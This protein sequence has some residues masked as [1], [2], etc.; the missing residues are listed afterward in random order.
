MAVRPAT[1]LHGERGM[2]VKDRYQVKPIKA[3]ETYDWL[4]NKHYAKR[5]PGSIL[6]SFGLYD[7]KMLLGV[8]TFGM[9]PNYNNNNIGDYPCIELNRLV[10]NDDVV[11]NTMSWFISK[12]M[13]Y[14]KKP[15]AVI[16][17]ADQG[18]N[19]FGVIYQASN[20][21]YTGRST[22]VDLYEMKNGKILSKRA[23]DQQKN[24]ESMIKSIHKKTYKH[25][26][27][28]FLGSKKDR[29]RM[30]KLLPYQVQPYPK[31]DNQRYDASYRPN[32]QQTLF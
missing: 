12:S 31:G 22:G 11:K 7:N 24:M 13:A 4:I 3:F 32:T 14:L 8:C 28:Y 20:F 6:Y 18:M 16:T 21:I 2:S 26:Y 9:S 19:H 15:C 29:K 5:I 1:T 10:V 27:F 30:M 23:L 17:Y 25:R